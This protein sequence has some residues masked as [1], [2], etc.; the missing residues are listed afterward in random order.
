MGR[1]ASTK[2]GAGAEPLVDPGL[3][4]DPEA[5]GAVVPWLAGGVGGE[6]LPASAAEVSPVGPEVVKLSKR[7]PQDG[8]ETRM[9]KRP[10]HRSLC[11]RQVDSDPR[12][13]RVDGRGL[14]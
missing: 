11:E 1:L 8:T 2:A 7:P 5:T 13:R 9:P 14:M 4:D 6:A 10:H 3:P 12:A